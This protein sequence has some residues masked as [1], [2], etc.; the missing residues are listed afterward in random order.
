MVYYIRL[1]RV[2]LSYDIKYYNIMISYNYT[3][4]LQHTNTSYYY[5]FPPLPCTAVHFGWQWLTQNSRNCS[6]NRHHPRRGCNITATTCSRK[7]VCPILTWS[8]RNWFRGWRNNIL[9]TTLSILYYINIQVDL[10]FV[11]DFFVYLL[12]QQY[13]I[14]II[15]H[16]HTHAHTHTHI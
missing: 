16:T 7:K 3:G 12:Q 6:K 15:I 9:Y 5:S 4:K 13:N 8:V 10:D 1:R 14:I 11:F 2:N